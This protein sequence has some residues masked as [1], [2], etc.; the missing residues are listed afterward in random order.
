MPTPPTS[1]GGQQQGAQ[2]EGKGRA[3]PRRQPRQ[4][5]LPEGQ[6][7][8]DGIVQQAGHP[9]QQ[10]HAQGQPVLGQARILPDG[11][12]KDRP[13]VKKEEERQPGADGRE[14]RKEKQ[15]QA[16]R[17]AHFLESEE[18]AR[19]RRAE[20]RGEAGHTAA[21]EEAGVLFLRA[22]PESPAARPHAGSHLDA[23]AFAPH[24]KAGAQ[25]RQRGHELAP[26]HAP[27]AH[28]R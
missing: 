28:G 26:E 18:Y 23:R 1:R 10:A 20:G 9:A 8:D 22:V 19:H 25:G 24:G 4:G 14:S 21:H 17:A 13:E 15:G 12:G 6:A 5:V 7:D 2:A 3:Q 16:Q 27:P 11:K